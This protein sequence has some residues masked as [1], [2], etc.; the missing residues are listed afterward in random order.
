MNFEQMKQMAR[1]GSYTNEAAAHRL[2]AA[3]KA[4]KLSQS[5]LGAAVSRN[6]TTIIAI[7][8]ARQLPS[9]AL[10]MW[11]HNHHRIDVNFFVAGEFSQL[12]GDVQEMLFESLKELE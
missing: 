10:M 7:E 11:F 9:W 5:D 12:P 6:A 4:C 8:K 1:T 2:L 3:R